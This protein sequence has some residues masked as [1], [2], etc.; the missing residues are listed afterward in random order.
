MLGQRIDGKYEL[1]Q[2]LGQG[3]MGVVYRARH[4]ATGRQVA[5]KVVQPDKVVAPGALERFQREARAMGAVADSQHVV[6]VLD[7]GADRDSG[8][9]F[10]VMELLNGEDVE[11][12]VH[13]LGPLPVGLALRIGVQALSGLIPAH[14]AGIVHR[15]IK[16]SNLFLTKRADG[17][18]I[19][20][21]LDFGIVK[22]LD[23]AGGPRAPDA[24]ALSK[25][26]RTGGTLGSPAYMSPEQVQGSRD[27]DTRTDLWSMGVV[28]YQLLCGV[29]PFHEITELPQ[30]LVA[31]FY[32]DPFPVTV[33]APWVPAEAAAVVHR[34]IQRDPAARY[35]TAKEM[36]EAIVRALGGATAIP[37]SMLAGLSAETRSA[38]AP[39]PAMAV[40]GPVPQGGDTTRI[41]G[42]SPPASAAGSGGPA[43]SGTIPLAALAVSGPSFAGA[44]PVAAAPSLTAPSALGLAPPASA[45]TV[46]SADRAP[47]SASGKTIAV[48]GIG[49]ITAGALGAAAFAVISGPMAP[50]H[51][52][53]SAEPEPSQTQDAAADAPA[54]ATPGASAAGVSEP[55]PDEGLDAGAA[56]PVSSSVYAPTRPAPPAGAPTGPATAASSHAGASTRPSTNPS[57][58][59]WFKPARP[60]KVKTID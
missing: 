60:A 10:M 36:R 34:A 11:A 54:E 39:V 33:R 43:A 50:A 14:E 6:Q 22:M 31:I 52:A 16:P 46:M 59:W 9:A 21:V 12:L 57:D 1:I 37:E 8:A 24:A 4:A 47:R 45:T 38:P 23:V 48:V 42:I 13:R 2:V 55:R 41:S 20:K 32:R 15:D 26:T 5:V 29:L 7:A 51:S 18:R 49:L 3:A 35:A 56:A 27:L 58:P 53:N 44:P 40:S 30:L 17:E 25:L 28:L 19:V